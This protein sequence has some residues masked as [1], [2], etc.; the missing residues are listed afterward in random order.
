MFTEELYN[1]FCANPSEVSNMPTQKEHFYSKE[2][3]P[4]GEEISL[5]DMDEDFDDCFSLVVA[6]LSLAQELIQT[7]GSCCC[8]YPEL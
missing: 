2:W 8:Y 7:V 4:A 6:M 5:E 1:P 3:R